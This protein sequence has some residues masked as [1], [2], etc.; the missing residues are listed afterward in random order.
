VSYAVCSRGADWC[1]FREGGVNDMYIQ[2]G[3]R[4]G[5]KE[6]KTL[7]KTK[8]SG[9]YRSCQRNSTEMCL[10]V[11]L[12]ILNHPVYSPLVFPP[13]TPRR[14][15]ASLR[16]SFSSAS[17][18]PLRRSRSLSRVSL[19][20][21]SRTHRCGTS[22]VLKSFHLLAPLPPAVYSLRDAAN[23][24]DTRGVFECFHLLPRYA[25]DDGVAGNR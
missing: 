23:G 1:Q 11:P 15:F 19:F 12:T 18:F 13:S 2:T 16:P 5:R 3:P 6:G 21:S 8:P 10:G 4:A 9:G 20:C 25:N 17:S 22:I 7:G 24:R 14:P